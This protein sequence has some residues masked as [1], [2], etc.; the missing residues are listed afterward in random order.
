MSDKRLLSNKWGCPRVT[1]CLAL[2]V[3]FE[4]LQ[5][6]TGLLPVARDG[7]FL[8]S[9]ARSGVGNDFSS[10]GLIRERFEKEST[11]SQKAYKGSDTQENVQGA[12]SGFSILRA[13]RRLE[14]PKQP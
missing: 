11:C 7:A 1:R 10:P 13:T 6:I 12:S 14:A 3:G 2:G 9:I 4:L 5:K 8:L